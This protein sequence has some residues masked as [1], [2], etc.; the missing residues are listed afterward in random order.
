MARQ[1]VRPQVDFAAVGEAGMVR[2]YEGEALAAI[3]TI[4][5]EAIS[6]TS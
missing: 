2:N 3:G 4:I 6:E 5:G 1:L